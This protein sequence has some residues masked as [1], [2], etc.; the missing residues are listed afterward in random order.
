MTPLRRVS[1]NT[2]GHQHT[3][4]HIDTQTH[5]RERTK[6]AAPAQEKPY[7]GSKENTNSEVHRKRCQRRSCTR[8][9]PRE[10]THTRLTANNSGREKKREGR[11]E[12][13]GG[14]NCPFRSQASPVTRRKR[15]RTQHA[16]AHTHTPKTDKNK[17]THTSSAD[18]LKW[19][20]ER[21]RTK[22][23]RA[24]E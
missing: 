11:K 18:V 1:P 12:G 21:V 16:C 23:L 19:R 15:Q 7:K 24:G 22:G 20:E 2:Q 5:K 4:T 13:E 10:G 8:V 6:R 17:K 9:W 14:R 3:H